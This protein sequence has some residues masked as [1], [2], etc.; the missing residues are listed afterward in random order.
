MQLVAL[1]RLSQYGDGKTGID[2]QDE[3]DRSY[4]AQHGHTIVHMAAD[5]ISGRVPP[6]KRKNAGRWLND[7][8]LIA[9]YDGILVSKI[10]RLT[11]HRDWDMRQWAEEHGKKIIV[12][13]PELI[14]PPE[15]GDIATPLVW[16]NLMNVA[17]AEWE[18]TSQRWRRMQKAKRDQKSFVGKPPY[19]YRIVKI[20]GTSI[21]TLEPD[22]ETAPIVKS[23]FQMY[24][25]GMSIYQIVG[26]LN[27]NGVRS[28]QGQV[29]G[30]QHN[31]VRR[32]LQNPS[33]IGRI[34]YKGQTVLRVQPLVEPEL[35]N[36]VSGLIK[37]RATRG[38][39][40]KD[41]ALL[42]GM[43][44]CD[45]G[46]PMYRQRARSDYFY[47]CNHGCP[48][49]S[50]LMV[51]VSQ[52]DSIVDGLIIE[53]GD[54]TH[55]ITVVTAGDDHKDEIDRIRL[56]IRDLDP[57]ADDYDARLTELREELKNLR[58]LPSTRK[59]E[60]KPSGKTIGEVW[61]S[62]DTAGKRRFLQDAGA[63]FYVSRD[64]DRNVFVAMETNQYGLKR[65]DLFGDPP[66]PTLL[67]RAKAKGLDKLVD[68]EAELD[69]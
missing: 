22:L 60:Q 64:A 55:I 20:D 11:R 50:R 49:G 6:S 61:Q 2:T 29:K 4:A 14:W 30:W 48:A 24:D 27:E 59:V 25:Q 26:W 3:D 47:Y 23:L 63:K 43:L 19:G 37:T 35:F 62:L 16:D 67:D 7:P 36:R 28:P 58:S 52:L 56:E 41:T 18:A 51:K 46:S 42:T 66:G 31:T 15:P 69:D 21:K 12:V 10:D 65:L 44:F 54:Q 17:N 68:A 39:G 53:V 8:N 34:R 13:N 5:H 40:R 33:T 57:E 38:P 9:M 1:A 45:N 32:I